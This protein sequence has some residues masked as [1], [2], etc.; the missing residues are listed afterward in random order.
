MSAGEGK[1]VAGLPGKIKAIGVGFVLALTPLFASA[2]P[3]AASSYFHLVE[4]KAECQRLVKL[5]VQRRLI[6]ADDRV[7]KSL[8]RTMGDL[9]RIALQAPDWSKHVKRPELAIKLVADIKALNAMVATP[10]PSEAALVDA[11]TLADRCTADAEE[12]LNEIQGAGAGGRAVTLAGKALYLSQRLTRDWML[13]QAET[14][15]KGVTQQ[16]VEKERDDL[17]AALQQLAALPTTSATRA[18]LELAQNQWTM[19]RPMLAGKATPEKEDQV[20]RI[21]ERLYDALNE[22]FEQIQKAVLAML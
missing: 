9:E 14:K 7:G 16:I 6:K 17:A 18:S 10:A 5:H 8:S 21:S 11:L 20:G 15:F 3:S 2:Q 22:S 19:L 1:P 13:M 4:A 12:A